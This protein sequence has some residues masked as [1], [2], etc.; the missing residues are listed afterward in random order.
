MNHRASGLRTDKAI[1]GFMQHKAAEGCSTTTLISYAQHLKAWGK[2]AGEIDIDAIAAS[3]L[4]AFLAWLRCDY[5]PRRFEGSDLPLSPKTL[6]NYWITLSAFFRWASAEFDLTTPMRSVPAPH[7][8]EAPVEP[9]TQTEVVVLLKACE[10]CQETKTVDRRRFTMRR[11]TA[12]C[13]RAIILKLL[14]TGLRA[15]ELCALTIGDVDQKTGKVQIKHGQRGG[16]KGGKG[17]LVFL[18]KAA[19][20]ALWRYLATRDEDENADSP[21]FVGKLN[22]PFNKNA[23]RQLMARLGT[24]AQVANCHPHR[25]RHTFAITYLRS[26]GDVFTLQTLLGH[27]TLEMA[28][29]YARIAQIDIEQAHR[30]AS[31]AD[32]WRL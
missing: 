32:N 29:H 18:G 21:L 2:Y 24:K 27:S 14:D 12:H 15:S 20:R 6:R 1:N 30:R 8:E 13:D 3:D 16:A 9:F 11:R 19:R 26:G 22:R 7:F 10:F 28:Q 23:L 5:K 31:P 25:F 17:R 4:R